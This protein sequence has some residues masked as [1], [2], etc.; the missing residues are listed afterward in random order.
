VPIRADQWQSVLPTSKLG[1]HFL[2]TARARAKD[3]ETI[4]I[5]GGHILLRGQIIIQF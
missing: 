2:A 1:C 3:L 5:D 4:I